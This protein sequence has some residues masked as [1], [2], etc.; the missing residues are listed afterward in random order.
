MPKQFYKYE[1]V[2]QGRGEENIGEETC[3]HQRERKI[4]EKNR[5]IQTIWIMDNINVPV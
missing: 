1:R 3:S 4:V 5:V 2:L